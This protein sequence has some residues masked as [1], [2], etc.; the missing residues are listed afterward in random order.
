MEKTPSAVLRAAA[1][2]DRPFALIGAWA[3]GRTIIGSNPLVAVEGAADPFSVLES[4]PVVATSEPAAIG[5]GWVGYLGYGLGRLVE[6]LPAPPPRPVPLPTSVLAFYDH[7]LVRDPSGQWWFEALWSD[8][9]S[10]RLEAR[11]S[12]WQSRAGDREQPGGSYKCGP[13]VLCPSAYEHLVAVA[14]AIEH[15]RSGDVFQVNVCTRLEAEF[16][17]DPVELFCRGVEQLKSPYGAFL[18]AGSFATASFSP[19]LF[20]RRDGRRVLSSPIKGTARRDDT[21][22]E[23]R[24]QLLSSTKDQAE[25]LMIVDLVRNDLGRVCRYGSVSV[26]QLWRAEEHPGVWHL[27]SDVT[28]E[29]RDEVGDSALLRASFPPG[30]VTGAPKVRA[31][32]LVSALEGSGRE[33]YTGAIGIASPL[34][35]LELN[36]AIRTFEL[37]GEKVWLGVGGGIVA[38]S[39]PQHELDECLDKA[40]PLLAAVGATLEVPGPGTSNNAVALLREPEARKDGVFETMLVLNGRPIALEA[41]LGRLAA[42]VGYLYGRRLPARLGS[43]VLAA[44]TGCPGTQ[45]LRVRVGLLAGELDWEVTLESA[46]EA[47]A[48]SPL[49]AITL[50]PV[51]M[52]GGFGRHK[53]HDRAPLVARRDALGLGWLE[54]LLLIDEDGAVLETELANVFSLRGGVIRTP[55]RDGRTLAGTTQAAIVRLARDAGLEVREEPF[56]AHELA[57]AEEVFLTSSIRGIRAVEALRG[58]GYFDIGSV[59]ARLAAALWASWNKGADFAPASVSPKDTSVKK[60]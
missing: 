56:D 24:A 7:V 13:F 55:P 41:H 35:G 22:T 10:E 1:L 39:D 17:G 29:L 14:R 50:V 28:G 49:P 11:L 32:E 37:A 26:P 31:M 18:A 57:L 46:P 4:H 23:E 48:G 20:L 40:R 3:G 43:E 27:V 19:E 52:R 45:R 5:G 16:S 47:F 54:Q 34:S 15:I 30:S 44:T 60:P 38:D 6:R 9:Q 42:S 59:T 53:W 33:I 36:V 2:D 58:H 51:V 12:Q 8:E 21:G 25:N